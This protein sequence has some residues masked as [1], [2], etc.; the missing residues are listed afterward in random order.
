[1]KKKDLPNAL[2]KKQK[3]AEI[4]RVNQ[5]GEYGAKR[6]YTGQLAI[7]KNHKEIKHM[8]EQELEHLD[9]FNNQ[10]RQRRVRPTFLQPIWHVGGFALGAIT[11]LM[12]EKAA[13]ACTV[14]V[15]EVIGE[16]YNQQLG[17]LKN[18]SNENEL[19]RKITKFRDEELEHKDKGLKHGA[20]EAICYSTLKNAIKA[21]TKTAIFLSKRI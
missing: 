5:A 10:V 17:E 9:Y 14:A 4:L 13:M 16:H 1:V 18:I 7:L 8:L 21:I 15:E 2:N 20:Q 3:L 6:I 19:T 12:G 11:A